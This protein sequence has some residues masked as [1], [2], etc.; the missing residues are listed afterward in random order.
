MSTVQ[1]RPDGQYLNQWS[2]IEQSSAAAALSDNADNSSVRGTFDLDQCRIAFG[3]FAMPAGA[4]TR[5]ITPIFR[6]PPT[7]PRG[8]ISNIR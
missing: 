4:V 6:C 7:P 1:L 2:V 5:T 8:P 3:S